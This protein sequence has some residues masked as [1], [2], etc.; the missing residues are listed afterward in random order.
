[1]GQEGE[2]SSKEWI[3]SGSG[4][5]LWGM[6]GVFRLYFSPVL[7]RKFQT[8]QF[9]GFCF[10]FYFVFIS[11]ACG[12]SGPGIEPMQEQYPSYSSDNA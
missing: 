12:S 10:V 2:I 11:V 9:M 1:M 3:V 4:H 5:L 6:E 7:N 8:D